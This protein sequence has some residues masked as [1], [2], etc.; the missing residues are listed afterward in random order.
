MLT[1]KNHQIDIENRN[2]ICNI[3]YPV[4]QNQI[5]NKLLSYINEKIYEDILTFKEMNIAQHLENKGNLLIFIDYETTLN[6]YNLISIPIVFSESAKY[7]RLIS[8]I[9]TYNFD[10]NKDKKIELK[11]IFESNFDYTSYIN[12]LIEKEIETKFNGITSDQTFYI[13]PQ[14]IVICFSSYELDNQYPGIEEIEIK[15]KSIKDHLTEYT[16]NYI[17]EVQN[18]TTTR[19]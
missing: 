8:Y 4:I 17:M 6:Q 1:I 16:K 18:E 11:D 19:I 2:L 3:E 15:F 10:I 14:S 12:N 13:T 5:N 9:N 7:N